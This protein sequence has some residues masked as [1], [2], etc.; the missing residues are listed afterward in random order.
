M[1]L[2]ILYCRS[3]QT[4]N[5][6]SGRT[7]VNNDALSFYVLKTNLFWP[8]PWQ[9]KEV[10]WTGPRTQYDYDAGI[11]TRVFRFLSMGDFL[12]ENLGGDTLLLYTRS[13]PSGPEPKSVI[14]DQNDEWAIWR[15]RSWTS[16][17]TTTIIVWLR[18]RQTPCPI[19]VYSLFCPTANIKT[20]TKRQ[21]LS[22]CSPSPYARNNTSMQ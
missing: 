6:S 10:I 9:N 13:S 17:I 7:V 21:R 11:S 18:R 19:S 12:H 5:P 8:W 16:T 15:R 22:S 3:T 2:I 4:I 20:Y 1:V 14:K